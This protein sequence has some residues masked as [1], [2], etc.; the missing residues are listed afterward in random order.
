M[1]INFRGGGPLD[2]Q[3]RTDEWYG[4]GSPWASAEM[5]DDGLL[6]L[7]YYYFAPDELAYVYAGRRRPLA[8][9]VS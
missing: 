5:D 8:T 6:W 1:P 7:H 4:L 3:S 2:G 9:Q